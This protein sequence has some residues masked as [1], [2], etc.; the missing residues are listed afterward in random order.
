MPTVQWSEG[1]EPL[2]TFASHAVRKYTPA[3]RSKCT[4]A[5]IRG[6]FEFGARA[7]RSFAAMFTRSARDSAFIFCIT[8]PRCAFNRDLA[9]AEFAADL[10]FNRPDTR[11][12]R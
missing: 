6:M 8:L 2:T 12:W 7:R 4:P 1:I 10:L 5:L 9:N 3:H 11:S